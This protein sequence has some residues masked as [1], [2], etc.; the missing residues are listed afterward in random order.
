MIRRSPP[1]ARPSWWYHHDDGRL[2]VHWSAEVY[3]D[4]DAGQEDHGSLRRPDGHD[5]V[6]ERLLADMKARGSEGRQAVGSVARP[7]VRSAPG[8]QRTH[9]RE[10]L[11]GLR[12]MA[13]QPQ[14]LRKVGRRKLDSASV[15]A[16]PRHLPAPP[17]SS[18]QRRCLSQA[19]ERRL[20][21]RRRRSPIF[22]IA[23]GNRKMGH[24]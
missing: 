22:W 14:L 8:L 23:G 10:R 2:L 1:T 3:A 11:T 24:R 6:F 7:G 18:R 20:S 21:G 5:V 19:A 12:R 13:N 17:N 16:A 15:P 4:G 9:L